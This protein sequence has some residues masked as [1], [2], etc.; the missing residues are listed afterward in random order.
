MIGGASNNLQIAALILGIIGQFG[1]LRLYF[2]TGRWHVNY[3]G[4]ALMNGEVSLFLGLIGSLLATIFAQPPFLH[5]W[6]DPL[7]T[8]IFWTVTIAILFKWRAIW[9][10]QNDPARRPS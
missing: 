2:K 6:I 9:R 8:F 5:S 3:I 10:V 1:F 7:L 4:R